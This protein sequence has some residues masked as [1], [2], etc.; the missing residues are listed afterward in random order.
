MYD[1]SGGGETDIL[2]NILPCPFRSVIAKLLHKRLI[3][4]GGLVPHFMFKLATI[5]G[6]RL[7]VSFT[8]KRLCFV[9]VMLIIELCYANA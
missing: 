4:S 7:C 6:F 5:Q 8:L 9:F 1:E 2:E 3:K